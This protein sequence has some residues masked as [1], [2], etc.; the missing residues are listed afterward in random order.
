[1][2]VG[3]PAL[4]AVLVISITITTYAQYVYC[5]SYNGP[6]YDLTRVPNKNVEQFP[7]ATLVGQITNFNTNDPYMAC[8]NGE[9]I[10][11]WTA[12]SEF[13]GV[14]V[15]HNGNQNSQC[16]YVTAIFTTNQGIVST[17]S[18]ILYDAQQII[19]ILGLMLAILGGAIYGGA[20]LIPG[21][22]RGTLQ[23]YAMGLI[24]G[25]FAGIIVSILSPYILQL[26]SGSSGV[27]CY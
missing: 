16:V 9:T 24:V 3:K 20:T 5:G 14:L 23:A 22:T 21:Q 8:L 15:M 2:R 13:P 27:L 11:V 10:N 26:I 7:D 18:A 19:S 12:P 25:G 6:I 17:L 1:M 4:I